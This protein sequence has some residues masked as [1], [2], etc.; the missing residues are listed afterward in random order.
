MMGQIYPI[1]Q[2]KHKKTYTTSEHNCTDKAKIKIIRAYK[3]I[4]DTCWYL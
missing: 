1:A 3:S 2:L 4:K